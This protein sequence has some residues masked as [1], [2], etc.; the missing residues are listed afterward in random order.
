[1]ATKPINMAVYA[2]VTK[3]QSAATGTKPSSVS[4][5]H[6]LDRILD[7]LLR[8]S[9][10]APPSISTSTATIPFPT[11]TSPNPTQRVSPYNSSAL[12]NDGRLSA[13]NTL[14]SN[15]RDRYNVTNYDSRQQVQSPPVPPPR[16]SNNANYHTLSPSSTLSTSSTTTQ[17]R[18]DVTKHDTSG[19]HQGYY[20]DSEETTNW[21]RKQQVRLAE[22]LD[23]KRWQDQ[24]QAPQLSNG[25]RSMLR[26]QRSS[27]QALRGHR[28]SNSTSQVCDIEAMM[29]SN[30]WDRNI[31]NS[32]DNVKELMEK[33][34]YRPVMED[35]NQHHRTEKSYFVAGLEKFS[36]NGDHQGGSS[37]GSST[38]VSPKPSSGIGAREVASPKAGPMIPQRGS[39]SREA[40]ERS[41]TVLHT[42]QSSSSPRPLTRQMSDLS[43]DRDDA[44]WLRSLCFPQSNQRPTQRSVYDE[45][46]GYQT[47]VPVRSSHHT[48]TFS[49]VIH[50]R[51]AAYQP[52]S[53]AMHSPYDYASIPADRKSVV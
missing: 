41:R 17:R 24:Q 20:S 51:I 40:V 39:S 29:S 35:R 3:R 33:Y 22:K 4:A 45:D 30:W 19:F 12:Y 53:Y 34:E 32:N 10:F 44:A 16:R 21:L 25:E 13:N 50:E 46:T 31:I 38:A 52:S 11:T 48:N 27:S 8:D 47:D 28:R 15:R 18:D 2:S 5:E 14:Q 26:D 1:M 42:F 23:A 49:N 37:V 43:F 7:E 6:E 36:G 9:I